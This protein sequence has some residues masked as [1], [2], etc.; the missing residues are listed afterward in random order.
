MS[1]FNIKKYLTL[2]V[3]ARYEQTATDYKSIFGTAIK[4]DDGTTDIGYVIDTIGEKLYGN[5]LPMFHMKIQP[6]KWFD[7]RLAATKA[8]SRPNFFSLVPWERF[9]SE[10]ST[11][12][13]GNPDLKETTSWSY[14]AFLSFYGKI[15]LFTIGGFYKEIENTAYLRERR[16]SDPHRTGILAIK[17][18]SR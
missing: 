6:L 14:D 4:R 5:L 2:L 11:W 18:Y 8:L 10:E 3:G 16:I 17:P 7:I 1:E 13:M 9:S 12:E 15:G